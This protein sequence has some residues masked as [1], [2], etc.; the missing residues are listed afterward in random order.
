MQFLMCSLR[1]NLKQILQVGPRDLRSQSKLRAFPTH[2]LLFLHAYELT[3]LDDRSQTCIL[4]K[5]RAF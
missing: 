2:L 1:L 5:L 3:F 4:L